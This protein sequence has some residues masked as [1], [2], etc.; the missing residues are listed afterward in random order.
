MEIQPSNSSSPR[1]VREGTSSPIDDI[2]TYHLP[3]DPSP[4]QGPPII[5]TT[6]PTPLKPRVDM[7]EENED[8]QQPLEQPQST[9]AFLQQLADNFIVFCAAEWKQGLITT[10]KSMGIGVLSC[11]G[12]LLF[13]I[14]CLVYFSIPYQI[15][16]KKVEFVQLSPSDQWAY[17]VVYSYSITTSAILLMM[18]FTYIKT[19]WSR[20]YWSISS[21]FYIITW[22]VFSTVYFFNYTDFQPGNIMFFILAFLTNFVLLH[23]SLKPNPEH[24]AHHLV[25]CSLAVTFEYVFCYILI[26]IPGLLQ[27][28]VMQW[29]SPFTFSLTS[30]LVRR[31]AEKCVAL[32]GEKAS[33][34]CIIGIGMTCVISRLTQVKNPHD[35]TQIIVLEVFYATVGI[36]TRVT[37]YW[38]FGLM[39]LWMSGECKARVEKSERRKLISARS[40]TTECVFDTTCF[41]TCWICRFIV[42]PKIDVVVF[43]AL[44]LGCLGVQ[45][46]S[47][48]LTVLLASFFEGIPIAGFAPKMSSVQSATSDILYYSTVAMFGILQMLD[49]IVQVW[50]P[51]ARLRW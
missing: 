6:S 4:P 42:G 32:P 12:T 29:M 21:I 18:M 35:Y 31:S 39:S 28:E 11:C 51:E 26:R 13:V 22:A 46:W 17:V 9:Q 36:L 49:V 20:K 7:E 37:L 15:E 34:L 10:A 50:V 30:T 38:R 45:L 43:I 23:Y 48:W 47:V 3:P 33:R 40:V 16:D 41:L 19:P 14:P 25:I 1:E 27:D 5:V 2:D 44:G 8:T 24:K